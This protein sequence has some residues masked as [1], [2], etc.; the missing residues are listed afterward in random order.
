MAGK[1][2]PERKREFYS[3]LFPF[4]NEL[5][6]HVA[7]PLETAGPA[8]LIL[9]RRERGSILLT[10]QTPTPARNNHNPIGTL[11]GSG[12]A[13]SA[14]KFWLPKWGLPFCSGC[15]PNTIAPFGQNHY[16]LASFRLR[17]ACWLSFPRFDLF[18]L[19]CA[20][21]PNGLLIL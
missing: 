11:R 20:T 18:Y 3:M 16:T 13:K 7:N 21:A 19:L 12:W 8:P 4:E 9:P 1:E 15:P 17:F 5:L 14:H 2:C 10:P 6:T